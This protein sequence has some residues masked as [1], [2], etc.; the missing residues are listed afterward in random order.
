MKDTG[1]TSVRKAAALSLQRL[2]SHRNL[3]AT[4]FPP[5]DIVGDDRD[6]VLH[7]AA[8]Q[9][10]LSSVLALLAE[11][12][13]YDL[14]DRFGR[15]PLHWAAEQGRRN[16]VLALLRAGACVD[17]RSKRQA[18]PIMLAASRGHEEVVKLLLHYRAGK[19]D[20]WPLNRYC[21]GSG[22]WGRTALHCAA[23]GG[24][25]G[26][27]ELLLDA[28]FD[29]GQHDGRLTP[30][31]VSA[32]QSHSTSATITHLL[33]PSDMG[34]KL[35][36]DWVSKGMENLATISGL[37]EGGAFL[38]WQNGTGETPLN[39]AAHLHNS[40]V[41]RVLLNAGADPN[42]SDRLGISPL[43]G[44]AGNW[45]IEAA[46]DLLEAGADVDQVSISGHCPLHEAVVS[47]NVNVVS[48]LLDAGAST[49]HRDITHGQTPLSW[50]CL[51]YTSPSPRDRQKSRM[52]S[53]A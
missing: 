44:A 10:M 48:L 11:R 37:V 3:V 9:G 43:H 4:I 36:H 5:S 51:L 35:V 46:A 19:S 39:R 28:G 6:E 41:S 40:T 49:E 16:V 1:S 27:V 38:D 24:H 26:V 22:L 15:T 50:A 18:T 30:A 13:S 23:K 32:R 47:N 12:Y 17:P 7:C 8:S 21:R 42:L 31:E 20:R 29:S 45:C 14:P 2:D 34:G 33:L 25:L 52:P 53:S